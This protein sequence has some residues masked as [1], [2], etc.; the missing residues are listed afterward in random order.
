MTATVTG[1]CL[2]DIVISLQWGS[3]IGQTHRYIFYTYFS[4]NAYIFTWWR[5]CTSALLY[6]VNI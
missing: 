5:K 3:S 4:H 1:I 6:S 2:K